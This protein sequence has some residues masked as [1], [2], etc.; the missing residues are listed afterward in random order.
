VNDKTGL[1]EG[2]PFL[3]RV[4]GRNGD[5]VGNGRHIFFANFA[6]FD[7]GLREKATKANDEKV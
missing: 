7:A 5:R 3:I 1:L 4:I 2:A 6:I